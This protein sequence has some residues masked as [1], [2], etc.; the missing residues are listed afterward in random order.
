LSN[1]KSEC[2]DVKRRESEQKRVGRVRRGDAMERRQAE[3]GGGGVGLLRLV[4]EGTT[5]II[6]AKS[7]GAVTSGEGEPER[8]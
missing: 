7:D 4:D 5:L 8:L 6:G 1:A 2:E 3:K